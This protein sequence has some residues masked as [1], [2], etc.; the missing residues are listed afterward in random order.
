MFQFLMFFLCFLMSLKSIYILAYIH[1]Y[2]YGSMD[3]NQTC[4]WKKKHLANNF[5][6]NFNKIN[7]ML[8]MVTF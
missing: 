5:L 3:P 6:F 2:L 1:I 7:K 8:K 4:I